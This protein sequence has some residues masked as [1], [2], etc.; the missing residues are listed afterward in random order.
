MHV[1]K[2][3]S[4]AA[5]QHARSLASAP[6]EPHHSPFMLQPCQDVDTVIA[7]NQS[8]TGP[9]VQRTSR[10][11]ESELFDFSPTVAK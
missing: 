3:M 4:K 1:R 10:R 8:A 5:W 2:V 7:M 6:N 9:R 11:C